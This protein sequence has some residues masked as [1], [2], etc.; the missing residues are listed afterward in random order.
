MC[1]TW[2]VYFRFWITFEKSY[3]WFGWLYRSCH[4]FWLKFGF[5][6]NIEFDR[7]GKCNSISVE[8]DL[9][10]KSKWTKLRE[11]FP[12]V[13]QSIQ[14]WM[15]TQDRTWAEIR[16][17]IIVDLQIQSIRIKL[18]KQC[19]FTSTYISSFIIF[20]QYEQKLS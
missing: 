1:S 8:V 3:L 4:W 16:T 20:I 7:S 9:D 15:I 5:E 18:N 2:N 10:Q 14:I 19:K 17:L 11:V 12:E 13:N 6:V